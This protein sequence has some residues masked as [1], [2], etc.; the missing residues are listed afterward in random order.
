MRKFKVLHLLNH[1]DLGGLQ[2]NTL[3]TVA[4]L[5]RNRYDVALAASCQRG[6]TG[7]QLVRDAQQIPGLKLIDVPHLTREPHPINDVIALGELY[8]LMRRER[9]DIV[10]THAAKAGVLGR[11]AAKLAGVPIIIHSAHGWIFQTL[12]GLRLRLSLFRFLEWMSAQWSD[13]ILTVTKDT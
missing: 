10:H 2:E 9:F 6:R 13:K 1:L 12:S 11:L 7:N 8:R 4:Y 5:D 3:F